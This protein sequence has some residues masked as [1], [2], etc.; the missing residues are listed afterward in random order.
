[1]ASN[2]QILAVLA[3]LQKTVN[4]VMVDAALLPDLKERTEE[5]VR[6]V[7]GFNGTPGLT[8][9]MRVQEEGLKGHI[10]D[11][12]EFHSANAA[13]FES[14]NRQMANGFEDLRTLF[15][16]Q[17]EK[18]QAER[19]ELD[20]EYRIEAQDER[21]DKRKF[22]LDLALAVILLTINLIVTMVGLK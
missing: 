14:M 20:K 3:D 5:L 18:E 12:N 4:G 2:D 16:D 22:R 17:I 11:Y 8:E 9:R 21:K 10:A 13:I 19:N 15:F 7:R 1:M 6:T